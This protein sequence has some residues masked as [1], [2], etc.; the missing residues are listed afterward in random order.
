MFIYNP[1]WV[2]LTEF[3]YFLNGLE[4]T[5]YVDNMLPIEGLRFFTLKKKLCQI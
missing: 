5:Y 4:V 3:R 2:P 1:L